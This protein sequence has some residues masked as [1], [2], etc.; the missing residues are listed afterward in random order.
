MVLQ[1]P[2]L[3]GQFSE[4]RSLQ[5]LQDSPIYVCCTLSLSC[6]NTDLG[7][8][9]VKHDH[10]HTVTHNCWDI[11]A[12][13]RVVHHLLVILSP[14]HSCS[15]CCMLHL[16]PDHIKQQATSFFESVQYMCNNTCA[17]FG[18]QK[19]SVLW[20]IH[21]EYLIMLPRLCLLHRFCA[22]VIFHLIHTPFR[23]NISITAFACSQQATLHV[24]KMIVWPCRN[25]S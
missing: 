8:Q 21:A 1:F 11:S 19:N 3:R 17:I 10:Q 16:V 18:A 6:C 7:L 20:H 2:M 25:L 24:P 15:R 22:C 4:L 9:H 13:I 5:S 12:C 23:Q 14:I